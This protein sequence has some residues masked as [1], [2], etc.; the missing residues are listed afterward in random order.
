MLVFL[1]LTLVHHAN[2]NPHF[3]A[4]PH[5]MLVILIL[6]LV[7]FANANP[8]SNAKPLLDGDILNPNT[9]AFC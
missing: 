6:T 5:S 3:N 7:R 9:S 2:A 1:I 8:Y 4:N